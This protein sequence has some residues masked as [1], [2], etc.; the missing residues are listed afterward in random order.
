M[1]QRIDHFIECSHCHTLI[2]VTGTG[3]KMT[4]YHQKPTEKKP[5]KP[6]KVVTFNAVEFLGEAH[7]LV[8][9]EIRKLF[10]PLK[11][12]SVKES[13]AAYMAAIAAGCTDESLL[14]EAKKAL[15]CAG[16]IKYLPKLVR[17]LDNQAYL[18]QEGPKNGTSRLSARAHAE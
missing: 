7:A 13:A 2:Q 11:D 9:F 15:R 17:F 14:A 1:P 3:S 5:P 12:Y 4:V 6:P 16:E 18:I 8:Y 10:T